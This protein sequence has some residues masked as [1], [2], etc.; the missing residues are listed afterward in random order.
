MDR[1]PRILRGIINICRPPMRRLRSL[2]R[3]LQHQTLPPFKRRRGADASPRRTH[4]QIRLGRHLVQPFLRHG[5]VRQYLL[6]RQPK[7]VN[8]LPHRDNV[9]HPPRLG[10][11]FRKLPSIRLGIEY[12]HGRQLIPV[13]VPHS[14]EDV[15][16]ILAHRKPEKDS[17]IVHR[18]G[19]R[20]HLSFDVVN[21]HSHAPEA[22]AVPAP[23]DENVFTVVGD[24]H[25]MSE[26]SM[27]HAV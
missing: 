2:Q 23:Q 24:G 7:D 19:G 20:P 1:D 9:A 15:Y 8:D 5:I 3:I 4:R 12:L 25:A 21:V 11:R 16:L 18:R 13:V 10:H 26:T 6:T 27:G 14:S 17:I 22:L